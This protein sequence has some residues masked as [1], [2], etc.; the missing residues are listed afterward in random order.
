MFSPLPEQLAYYSHAPR[1]MDY[2]GPRADAVPSKFAI[3]DRFDR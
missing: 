2:L 1:Q 3:L